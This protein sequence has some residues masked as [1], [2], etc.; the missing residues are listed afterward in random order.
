MPLTKNNAHKSFV[1]VR[2]TLSRDFT[3]QVRGVGEQGE[4]IR[5]RR[6][7][8]AREQVKKKTIPSL[9]TAVCRNFLVKSLAVLA[10]LEFSKCILL[11]HWRIFGISRRSITLI[12]E[13]TGIIMPCSINRREIYPELVKGSYVFVKVTSVFYINSVDI[14]SRKGLEKIYRVV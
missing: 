8:G 5:V 13:P 1:L 11:R 7:G 6:V 2:T 10:S 9:Q 12:S 3:W 4:E 14:L